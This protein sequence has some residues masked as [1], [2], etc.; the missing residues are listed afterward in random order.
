M[1]RSIL[2]GPFDG[3]DHSGSKGTKMTEVSDDSWATGAAYEAYMGRWSRL[4]ARAFLEWLQA[5]PGGHWL[6]VGCGTGSLT[7][8]ICA[9]CEPT[10]V[11][12]SDPSAAF[13]E[14]ARS[15]LSDVR[16]SF[17]TAAADTLPRRDGG[18]DAVISGLVLNFIQKPDR[19][20]AAMRER[21]RP[22]G[23]VAAYVWEYAGGVEFLR[24]FW[25][26]AAALDP[27]AAALDEARR[28]GPWQTSTLASLFRGA[29]LARVETEVIDIPTDFAD[30]DDYWKPFLGG[31][32]PA[33]SY[34]ASLDQTQCEGLRERLRR[35]IPSGDDGRIQFRARAS[36]V[37]GV[38]I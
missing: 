21:V 34:V 28:F 11:V 31:T 35:R 17:V 16:T 36:A 4:L 26:E 12:A 8:S 9:F 38:A 3:A 22:G 7:A 1:I 19:A 20:L 14:H 15:T 37:R 25:D 23:T 13:I 27:S 30:F 6:E 5:K 33:P 2:N 10:S 29:G 24:H 32:G 18:F